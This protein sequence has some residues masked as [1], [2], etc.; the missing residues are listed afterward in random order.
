MT[1]WAD[2]R[3]I[4][5]IVMQKCDGGRKKKSQNRN[6]NRDSFSNTNF[7]FGTKAHFDV[8]CRTQTESIGCRGAQRFALNI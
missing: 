4:R 7:W 8:P 2:C 6:T 1:D 5:I 3:R